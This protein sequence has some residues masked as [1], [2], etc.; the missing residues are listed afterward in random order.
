MV[1]T[2]V[3]DVLGAENN[4]TTVACMNLV[5]YL[6][7]RGDT[8]K[9]VCCDQDKKDLPGYYV[10]PTLN[11]GPII[12]WAVKKNGVTLAK[13]VRSIIE[14]A[15]EGSDV[16]HCMIPFALSKKAAKI[17]KEKDIPLTAG[18]HM[19]AE[20]FTAHLFLMN[21]GIANYFVYQNIYNHFYKYVDAIHYPTKFIKN[22]FE[23]AI[24]RRTNAYVISNGVND[25]FVHKNIEKPVE[26]KDKFVILSTGR[27]SKEKAQQVL[28]KAVKYSKY[29]DKIQIILA[30][31]GPKKAQYK[32]LSDK[33]CPNGVMMN[34]YGRDEIVD[35]I[36]Y[37]DLY[38]HTA[39]C[40]LEGIACLEALKCGLVPVIANSNR[41]ATKGFA[42]DEK[43]LF[44]A[45]SSKDLARKIDF[46]IE[47]P[48]LRKEYKKYYINSS[49]IYDQRQCMEQT[50]EMLLE[51]IRCR[52]NKTE[53]SYIT[54]MN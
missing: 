3:A 7:E 37:S 22:V 38:C 25:R 20:N 42:K 6:K 28:I 35:V 9:I 21:C 32:K 19:Q 31:D 5:R 14:D 39:V 2:I 23:N 4:G 30:G 29:K 15:I 17:C 18:F 46:W 11:L 41:C 52:K 54:A 43:C 10:V 50:R 1:V 16:V 48:E 45:N 13:P 34:F 40:E 24:E 8:V 53:K 51:A 44:K 26:L 12:N 47:H 33:Y 49:S 27:Y 36:N